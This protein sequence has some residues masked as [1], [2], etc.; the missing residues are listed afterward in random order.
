MF[1]EM[2]QVA[3][4]HIDAHGCITNT[5]HDVVSK[6][7]HASSKTSNDQVDPISRQVTFGLCSHCGLRNDK[8]EDCTVG[9]SHN[10]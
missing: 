1:K 7:G 4:N 9:V 8:T 10:Q 5:H 6:K 3:A 2:S